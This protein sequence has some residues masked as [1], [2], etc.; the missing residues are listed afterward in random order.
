[1]PP[2]VF[3]NEASVTR[4]YER[5]FSDVEVYRKLGTTAEKAIRFGEMEIQARDYQLEAWAAIGKV[6]TAGRDSA[7]VHLATGL[8]KT[9]VGVV[10]S[11]DFAA[12]FY[13]EY[14]RP[15]KIMFAVHQ[16]EI[17]EQAAERYQQFAPPL[18]HGYYADGNT[19][20]KG[21]ITFATMQSLSQNLNTLDPEEFDYIIYDEAHHTQAETY[22]TV[23]KH[24]MPAFKLALTATPD[25]MDDKDIRDLFGEAVYSKPLTEAMAEGY[26]ADVDYHIVFDE[27]VKHAMEAGFTPDTL[28]EIRE[29]L[30]NESRNEEIAK[31]IKHEM[32]RIEL[33][34]AKTIVFCQTV[35][36]ASEMAALLDGMP[37]HSGIPSVT[38]D[39]TLKRFR[40]G[41]IQIIT[42]R[43]MF[44]EGVDIPDARLLVFLR[45]TSSRT[46]F[47]QQLGRGLRKHTDKDTVSVL[48]FVANIERLSQ[49]KE[50]SDEI[51]VASERTDDKQQEKG[52]RVAIDAKHGL[53]VHT[54]HT[55]F[56]FNKLAVDLLD[57]FSSL[58]E[59]WRKFSEL[60]DDEVIDLALTLK[61]D[62]P[63]TQ[64]EI[65]TLSKEHVFLGLNSI[66]H[67][68]GS[69]TAFQKACGFEVKSN[70]FD[71]KHI[72]NEELILIAQSISPDLPLTGD[73]INDLS[74]AGKFI[75]MPTIYKR[76]GSMKNF[77]EACG[78]FEDESKKT[79]SL[80]TKNLTNE[81]I[82]D[83]AISLHNEPM[84]QSTI[85][86]YSKEGKF[87]S[88]STI[89]SRFGSIAA[90]HKSCGFHVQNF[91]DMTNEELIELA[92]SLKDGP[93][94]YKEVRQLAK[95]KKFISVTT[96][97]KRFGSITEFRKECGY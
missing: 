4:A 42:T 72:T 83:I 25:R 1:M 61:V 36:Q 71:W 70:E 9:T 57:K 68:F 15:P 35:S 11:L 21:A 38:R 87:V 5:I 66:T 84:N 33:A 86:Q 37:Y 96:L 18:S 60:S 34:K 32:E 43:D 31:Q 59:T 29:L 65:Q 81:A 8:G 19:D 63:L 20:T 16:K 94:E 56:D 58:R 49:V 12:D 88:V 48:D 23:V 39:E 78:F 27:A 46:I 95:E 67:R 50:L 89:I 10:D 22:S 90:F 97:T 2:G 26:L 75:S 52:S 45:S 79:N 41:G 17:L 14:G 40:S 53:S 30:E 62:G 82:I 55:T 3:R 64:K 76:F 92:K 44:N 85:A 47:E 80:D 51:A 74:K 91:R 77:K 93:L 28:Y 69:L 6:R 13:K 24:F 54:G 7:L 73:K